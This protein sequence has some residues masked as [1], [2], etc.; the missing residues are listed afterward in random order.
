MKHKIILLII[1]LILASSAFAQSPA[2]GKKDTTN[3]PG[4]SS[5]PAEAAMPR[6]D[7]FTGMETAIIEVKNKEAYL[8]TDVVRVLSSL[9]GYLNQNPKLNIITVRDF[10]EN[11]AKIREAIA[12]LDVEETKAI[13]APSL[14]N[15]EVQ[16]HLIATS[17]TSTE[18]GELPAGLEPVIAQLQETLR[19]KGYR[20]V[21]SFLNRMPPHE[22]TEASG[23]TDPLFP[24]A[25]SSGKSFYKYS[26]WLQR[27]TDS[28]GRESIR[29]SNFKFSISVPVQYMTDGKT[30]VNYTDVG[31]ST[32]VF[33]REGEKVVVGTANLG[34][35]DG[36]VIVVVSARKLAK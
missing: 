15:Y 2:E 10:P 31:I 33:L 28:T 17:R 22:K 19:Y 25:A 14:D 3:P 1:L 20:Y 7:A 16:L 13:S 5:T 26:L 4:T 11:V 21:T 24:M 27:G 9:R 12:R 8:I 30:A 34:S 23:I 36:A 32:S 6:G 29:L 35:S 18:K